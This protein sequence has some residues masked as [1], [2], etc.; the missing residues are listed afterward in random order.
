MSGGKDSTYAL[1][2]LVRMGFEVYAL[3]LDNGFISDEAKANVR[4]TVAALG[5]DHEMATTDAMAA[6][7]KDS[8]ERHSNVCH[9]CFKTIYTLGTNRA[10][11]L[12]AP[13]VVTGLSRGQLFET[14]L[15]PAQFSERRFDPDAIDEA[16]VAARRAY[17][18]VD[19][20]VRRLLDTDV[21]D[22]DGLFE[23]V[24][25]V[26]FYRYVDVDLTEMLRFLDEEAPWVRP[27][28]TGRSTNCRINAAG[29]QTHLLEQ[30]YH[31]YA[32]PYAWDVRLGH[33]TRHE[34]MEE[35]DDRLDMAEVQS[36]LSDVGYEPRPKM[37]AAL[38]WR[39][40]TMSRCVAMD[41]G[42][43]RQR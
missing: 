37:S 31:N 20:A 16:V 23:R 29:I 10:V 6:I 34:A 2:Q 1:F 40:H 39:S 19:D 3:T 32:E 12:G 41:H 36:M 5:I 14:R 24:R 33:K 11:E 13:L 35:L 8:L 7:F 42:G 30:G 43:H 38:S 28:D 26:D 22:D 4:S 27:T 17:H 18:R 25:Y 21:F 15:I 9:G